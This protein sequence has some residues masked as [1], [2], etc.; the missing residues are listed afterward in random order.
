MVTRA[1]T[2]APVLVAL[3]SFVVLFVVRHPQQHYATVTSQSIHYFSRLNEGVHL[4]PISS[5]ASWVG[6]ELVDATEKWRLVLTSQHLQEIEA[7]LKPTDD[8]PTNGAEKTTTLH[9]LSKADFPLGPALRQLVATAQSAV[10]PTVGLGFIVIRGVPV[11]S[12]STFKSERFF[13]GLGLHLGM[14]GAQNNNG[15]LL[16]HVRDEVECC[17]CSCESMKTL[18]DCC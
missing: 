3:L 15:E 2:V 13:W 11:H 1:L 9:H 8:D 12:W 5:R 6:S 16:G 10:D 4:Q 18:R 7:M 17:A 14:P